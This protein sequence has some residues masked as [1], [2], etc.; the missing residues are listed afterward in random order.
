MIS[1]SR[2]DSLENIERRFEKV[3]L[4]MLKTGF[5]TEFYTLHTQ[6]NIKKNI[7]ALML[8]LFCSALLLI[9]GIAAL[10]YASVNR[11]FEI[12]DTTVSYSAQPPK[13]E[14]AQTNL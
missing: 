10:P 3:Y 6:K 7:H 14:S 11:I 2:S 13:I 8:M 12:N 9:A 1:I 4:T 5:A